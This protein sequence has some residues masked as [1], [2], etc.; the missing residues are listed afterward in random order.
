MRCDEK[1]KKKKMYAK[2]T[3]TNEITLFIH[4]GLESVTQRWFLLAI[5]IEE[6]NGYASN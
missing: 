5:I 4:K 1:T 6:K 3:M 2:E